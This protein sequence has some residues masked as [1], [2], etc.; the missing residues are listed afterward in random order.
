MHMCKETGTK[1]TSHP[2]EEV[3]L[4]KDTKVLTAGKAGHSIH[5]IPRNVDSTMI[6]SAN[7]ER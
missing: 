1:F 3:G 5:L 4:L 2:G 6:Q 7:T